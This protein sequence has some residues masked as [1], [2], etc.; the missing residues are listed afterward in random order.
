MVLGAR[1]WCWVLGAAP[2]R[3]LGARCCCCLGARCCCVLGARAAAARCCV[4]GAW[5]CV[6]GAAVLGAAAAWVLG[7]VLGA[8]CCV[9][10]APRSRREPRCCCCCCCCCCVLGA[11]A[12]C[13]VLGAGCSVLCAWCWVLCAWC[14]VSRAPCWD[15]FARQCSGKAPMFCTSFCCAATATFSEV[16]HRCCLAVSLATGCEHG[17]CGCESAWLQAYGICPPPSTRASEPQR[18]QIVGHRVMQ[19][20]GQLMQ[21]PG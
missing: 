15:T 17:V 3:C 21:P 7:A 1:A 14:R 12:W 2:A 11:R 16:W 4:L 18:T 5:C 20:P 13:W 9:P 10:G 8:R 19:T 6:L